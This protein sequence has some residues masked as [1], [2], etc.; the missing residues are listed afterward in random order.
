MRLI[1]SLIA[2]YQRSVATDRAGVEAAQRLAGVGE[3]LRAQLEALRAVD[4][5]AGDGVVVQLPLY[6]GGGVG[7][8]DELALLARVGGGEGVALGGLEGRDRPS[9]QGGGEQAALQRGLLLRPG[10]RRKGRG[11]GGQFLVR[12]ARRDLVEQQQHLLHHQGVLL[13]GGQRRQFELDR[14]V[15]QRAELVE[16]DHQARQPLAA[17]RGER[18]AGGFRLRLHLGDGGVD[19]PL[20]IPDLHEGG[21]GGAAGG[22]VRGRLVPFVLELVRQQRQAVDQLGHGTD[23]LELRRAADRRGHPER[24][25]QNRDRGGD[26]DQRDKPRPDPPVTQRERAPGGWSRPVGRV[27]L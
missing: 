23:A 7:E 18:V 22:D 3:E 10:Q 9:R 24:A 21:S 12:G 2:S 17:G 13:H 26:E 14:G 19:G 27:R 8:G 25:E 6:Q 5:L 20:L 1:V 4:E 11:R 16:P 15:A